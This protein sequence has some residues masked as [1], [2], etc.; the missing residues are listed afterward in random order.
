[1]AKYHHTEADGTAIVLCE[2]CD[3]QYPEDHLNEDGKC[4]ECADPFYYIEFAEYL[5]SLEDSRRWF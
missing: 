4:A 5:D 2:S 1:M 3:E